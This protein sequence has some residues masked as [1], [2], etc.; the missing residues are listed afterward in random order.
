MVDSKTTPN[1]E[2]SKSKNRI[3]IEPGTE[4]EI[5][6]LRQYQMKNWWWLCLAIWLTIGVFS[7]WSMRSDLAEMR[8]YFTWT[9]VR[10]MLAYNRL[11]A[12]GLGLSIGLTIATLYAESRHI[13]FGLSIS[14]Q[15]QL[16]GRLAKIQAQGPSHPQWKIIQP[17][18]AT[19]EK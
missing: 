6:Y 17:G 1:A 8:E 4:R 16:A 10:Y 18:H 7:L 2:N 15:H 9:A 19:L 11:A 13:L 3:I 12:M 14:E 5:E